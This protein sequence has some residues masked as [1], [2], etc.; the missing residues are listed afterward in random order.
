MSEAVTGTDECMN[1]DADAPAPAFTLNLSAFTG[2]VAADSL[3]RRVKAL[4]CTAPLHALETNKVRV[5]DGRWTRLN[6]WEL[7][8]VAI[9]AVAVAMDFDTGASYDITVDL[10]AGQAARQDPG[11]GGDDTRAAA[12]W[13]VEGLISGRGGDEPFHAVY[14]RWQ[15]SGPYESRGF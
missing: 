1:W 5:A 2:S 3:S 14:G 7:G 13:V 10:V 9:D 4:A 6:C 12:T 8:F 15:D 11:L